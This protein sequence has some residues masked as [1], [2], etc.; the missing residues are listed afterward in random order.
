MNAI[1]SDT[2]VIHPCA[3][4]M[5]I[6]VDEDY[7]AE[8]YSA[9]MSIDDLPPLPQ[10]LQEQIDP[11]QLQHLND[12]LG[13]KTTFRFRRARVLEKGPVLPNHPEEQ[14][15]AGDY[16]YFKEGH[17]QH[18][19]KQTLMLMSTPVGFSKAD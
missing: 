17:G 4:W 16:V 9:R 5:R 1:A 19:G 7:V 18:I 14:F 8:D 11:E 12:Q 15:E 2:A 13:E 3:G 6:E 10:E